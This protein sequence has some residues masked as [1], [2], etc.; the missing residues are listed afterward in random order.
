MSENISGWVVQ[1]ATPPP[2][3][4]D[5]RADAD[6]LLDALKPILKT[7]RIFCDLSLIRYLPDQLRRWSYQARCVCFK[8]QEK[9]ELVGVKDI[10][11]RRSSPLFGN[12]H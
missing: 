3:L 9:W 12:R 10:R 4:K 6:R 7:D 1:A 11:Y 2:S 8:D 5:N